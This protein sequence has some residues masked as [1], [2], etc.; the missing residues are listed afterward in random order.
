MAICLSGDFDPDQAMKIIK[1]YFGGMKP[2]G[3]VPRLAFEP[4]ED[5]TAPVEKEVFGVDAENVTLAWRLPGVAGNLET[6][7]VAEIASSV[8]FNGTAGLIDLNVNQ[9]QKVLGAGAYYEYQPDYSMLMAMGMPKQGQ[10]LEEVRD[11]ILAEVARLAAGDFTEEDVQACKNNYRLNQMS[12]LTNNYNRAIALAASFAYDM[13][14]KDV[15]ANNAAIE[16]VTKED[17]VAFAGKY[18]CQDNYAVVYKRVGED[19]D[20]Q[21]IAAPKITPIFM[22]RDTSSEFLRSIV[23][24]TPKPIEPVFLDFTKDLSVSNQAANVDMLYRENT[25]N[26]IFTVQFVYN[27]GANDNPVLAYAGDYLSYLGTERMSAEDIARKMYALACDYNFVCGDNTFAVSV[28]GLKE[29]MGEAVS[30]VEDLIANARGDENVLMNVK[31]D[32]LQMRS[33]NKMNQSANFRALLNYMAVGGEKI[34]KITLT[35]D[36]IF[37]LSSDQILSAVREVFAKQHE[38]YYYGPHTEAEVRAILASNHTIS[39]NPEPLVKHFDDYLTVEDSKV[40]FA[41][42]DS[43]QL[44]YYQ[45]SVDDTPFDP[46]SDPARV[47]YNEYFGGSM[48]A[49]VFQELRES[50]GLAYSANATMSNPHY[51]GGKYIYGAFIATQNDKMQ[52]AAEAFADIINNMPVSENAFAIAKDAILTRLRTE[53]TTGMGVIGQYVRCRDMGLDEPLAKAQFEKIKDMTM[54]DVVAYQQKWIKD[55]KYCYGILGDENDIDM[56]FIKTLGPVQMVSS[57]DIF[58][59]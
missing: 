29:N 40:V 10:T 42:Y 15:V 41:H 14:W 33:N 46:S 13:P 28:T 11:I 57:E 50:R 8:L 47:L 9:Q 2:S 55:R 7:P 43:R 31:I 36:Q 6:E 4:E 51:D 45:I 54:D 21:K 3:N 48:N 23:S 44:Y 12:E 1:K 32:N 17:V 18:L 24:N 56:E 16:K 34:R 37:A 26:D 49:V 39:E 22:N 58:G 30:I 20:I 19:P 5:I 35:N 38:I 53:R 52:A 27:C 25:Q 59:Y